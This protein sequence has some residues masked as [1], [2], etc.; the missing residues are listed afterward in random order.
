MPTSVERR[1]ARYQAWREREA[2]DRPMIGLLWEPDIPPLPEMV[3]RVGVGS[4]LTPEDIEPELFLPHI[5]RWHRRESELPGDVIQPYTPAFG[6]PWVEAIAGC[7]VV[8]NPGSLW[9]ER[10][11]ESYEDRPPIRFDPENPWLVKLVELTRAMVEHSNGRFPIALPQMRGPLDTLGALRG[12]DQLC[13]DL[14]EAPDAVRQALAE[15]TDL[16][17]AIADTVLAVIP[18]FWGGYSTR[19]KMWAPGEAIT[20]QNDISTLLSPQA[21]RDFALPWDEKIVEH[22]PYHSF[23]MHSTEHHQIDNLLTLEKLTAIQLTIE[24]EVGGPPLDVMLD[25]A[26]RVLARKPL[27]LVPLDIPTAEKCLEVL[28]ARGLCLMVGISTPEIDRKY[29]RWLSARCS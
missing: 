9:A 21:Y 25:A 5:E 10:S 4:D 29:D 2:V 15:L 11:L 24:Q 3:E 7:R 20:P 6:T 23:H 8:V 17:I 16:W 18:E 27:L 28:P 12:A 1:I 14:I 13:L 26:R 19:M 22:F